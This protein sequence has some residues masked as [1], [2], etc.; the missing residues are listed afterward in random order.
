VTQ[1][2]RKPWQYG[3]ASLFWLT[4]AVAVAVR[5]DVPYWQHIGSVL[6]SILL[7]VAGLSAV[8]GLIL[9]PFAIFAFFKW[10]AEESNWEMLVDRVREMTRQKLKKR[11]DSAETEP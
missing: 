5:M 2:R 4:T 11:D 7:A 8:G 10:L 6:V 1:R 9:A 3:L